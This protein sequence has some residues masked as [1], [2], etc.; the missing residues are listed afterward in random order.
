MTAS[1]AVPLHCPYCGSENLW[2][3]PD[4][5]AGWECRSCLRAFTISLLG[6][7]SRHRHANGGER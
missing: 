7:L 4:T 3:N 1:R 5:H 2:P 6:H